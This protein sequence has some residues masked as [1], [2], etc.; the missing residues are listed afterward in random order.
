MAALEAARLGLLGLDD[1][2][3][4]DTPA[5]R[6]DPRVKV[7][8]TL[9]FV[10]VVASFGRLELFRLAPLVLYPLSM[11]A[12]GDV[13]ARPLLVRL[14]VASPFAL[15]VA[16]FEPFLDRSP[17]LGLG[18]LTLSGGTLA[19]LTI[20]AK[21]MLSLSAALLLVATTRFDEV[22]LALRRL[23]VPRALITQLL[24]TWRYLFVLAEEASR[25]M[26]AHALR[27][28]EE[29]R[30]AL[31]T[32]GTLL[33]QLLV[34]SLGRAERIH[35]AMRCRGFDGSLPLRR[36]WTLHAPDAVFAG[37]T[38]LLLMAA[39]AIDLPAWL[40]TALTGGTG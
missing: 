26:R 4:L 11:A 32:A 12:L 27:A 13:P 40:G 17:A 15:G 29:P 35:S 34:R 23:G 30:P 10:A 22:C 18:P 7:V 8:F 31:R 3:R 36:T 38:A 2:A 24:L 1:L 19:L 25:L 9:A 37:C 16:A 28:P 33:G 6:L 21:F 39:R 20:L 5:T 14:L